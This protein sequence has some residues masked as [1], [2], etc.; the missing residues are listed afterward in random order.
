MTS[1]IDTR[2]R[3]AAE[4]FKAQGAVLVHYTNKKP[5]RRAIQAHSYYK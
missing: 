3:A 4:L 5:R 2:L 1:L